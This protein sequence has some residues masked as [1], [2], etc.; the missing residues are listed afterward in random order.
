[1]PAKFVWAF[2][3]VRFSEPMRAEGFVEMAGTKEQVEAVAAQWR[4]TIA[5]AGADP[6]LAL[7]GLS[8][9]V[10]KMKIETNEHRIEFSL[11][12][13]S[14]QIQAALIMLEMQ[15]GSVDQLIERKR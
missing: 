11:P 6:L 3:E 13:T 14:R 7:A 2:A 12:L 1:M 4:A 15:A 5:A 8:G 10:D 9:V